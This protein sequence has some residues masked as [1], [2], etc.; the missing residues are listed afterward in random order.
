MNYAR[1]LFTLNR[2]IKHTHWTTKQLEEYQN[3]Q[4]RQVIRH[5]YDN[6]PFYH[7][8]MREANLTPADIKT[9]ADLN[10]LPVIRKKELKQNAPDLLCKGYDFGKLRKVSTSGSTGEPL[11]LYLS[12]PELEFRK[13]KHLRANISVGQ[14]AWHRW[15][16]LVGPQHANKTGSLQHW[17]GMYVPVTLSVYNGVDVQIKQLEKLKPNVLD[18]YSSSLLVLAQA[19]ECQGAKSFSPN[20][21][22]G[23]A[24]LIDKLSRQYIQRVFDVPLYDQY[25]SV[26][27]ERMAWQCTQQ[28]EYHMDADGVILQFLDKDGCEV[29]AGETGEVVCT[30]LFN[31]AMPLIRYAIGDMGIPSE[32]TC[33]CGCTLPL[34][35]M[36]EGR[37]DSMLILPN[38]Q[39]LTPRAFTYAVHE[40]PYYSEIE[41]FRIIQKDTDQFE[42]IL[43]IKTNHYLQ[44]VLRRELY[45]HLTSLLNLQGAHFEINFVDDIPLDR[46]G[47]LSIVVS[48]L[49]PA[50]RETAFFKRPQ[51]R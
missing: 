12:E 9:K 32:E 45:R 10:K 44:E 36:V 48:K 23:G 33:S 38:G 51:A 3:K 5:A 34:M 35:K 43:K 6:V 30:S 37:K 29:S 4:L 13:A 25:S 20:F 49:S 19:I 21:L 28:S 18:G 41:K 42:L 40:F 24:E 47:K 16:T 46:N 27:F 17:L 7:K 22:I 50:S 15:I 1:A 8:K 39:L 14:R 26:E 11:F 31:Y 2:L